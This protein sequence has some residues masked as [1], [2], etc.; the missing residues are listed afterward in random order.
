[1]NKFD[2]IPTI[3]TAIDLEL[4]NLNSVSKIIEIGICIKDIINDKV[5][6]KESIYINAKE[7]LTPYIKQLTRIKQEQVDNGI[8]IISG[9]NKICRLHNKYNSFVNPV[10][11]GQGDLE[12]LT[13]AVYT[14]WNRFL[15]RFGFKHIDKWPFGRR[16]IDV[17]TLYI[18]YRLAQGKPMSGGLAKALT[19]VGLAF[20]GTIHSASDDCSN[21]LSMF[22]ALLKLFKNDKVIKGDKK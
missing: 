18:S 21:T 20:K 22:S 9:Y 5:L 4:N 13:K 6:H 15:H 2:Q 11:W 16:I 8:D 3:F 19:K 1:M 12:A 10:T 17:K 7:K 14:P